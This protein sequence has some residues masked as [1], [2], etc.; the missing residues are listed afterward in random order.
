MGN[1]MNFLR[2]DEGLESVDLTLLG[3]LIALGIIIGVKAFWL[4]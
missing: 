4:D 2:N 1:I 3:M